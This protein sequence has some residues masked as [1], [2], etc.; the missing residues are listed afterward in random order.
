[1]Q[2]RSLGEVPIVP[3]TFKVLY[4]AGKLDITERVTQ[5]AQATADGITF[6]ARLPPGRHLLTVQVQDAQQRSAERELRFEV[7]P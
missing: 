6:E 3:A 2:F 5:N 1:M 7:E 4:G